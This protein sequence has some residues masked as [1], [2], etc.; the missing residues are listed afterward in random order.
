MIVDFK[1][2]N[3]IP[4]M[5]SYS[6]NEQFQTWVNEYIQVWSQQTPEALDSVALIRALE[7]TNGCTQYAFRLEE[8]YALGLEQTRLCMSTSM[9]AIKSKK[10]KLNNGDVIKFDPSIHDLLDE[11]RD[12]Y[13]DGF[14]KGDRNRMMQFYAQ[15]V[16][17]FYV[18]GR[19]RLE[20]QLEFIREHFE[21]VFT[22]RF[23]TL[24][25]YYIFSYLDVLQPIQNET[26]S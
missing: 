26:I 19:E 10:L 1:K 21:D 6:D 25:K 17:Q 24:G 23:L 3:K 16:A 13:V 18:L 14:K 12:I 11:V 15:S 20:K 7:C 22:D 8:P 2:L 5:E 9:S 4:Y